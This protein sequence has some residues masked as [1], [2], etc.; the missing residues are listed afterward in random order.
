MRGHSRSDSDDDSDDDVPLALRAAQQERRIQELSAQLAALERACAEAQDEAAKAVRARERVIPHEEQVRRGKLD[1]DFRI[2][3]NLHFASARTQ[4]R[5][6]SHIIE[7]V[8]T[9]APYKM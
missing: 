9:V 4:K 2:V 6:S 1:F 8:T 3:V 7:Y 5:E